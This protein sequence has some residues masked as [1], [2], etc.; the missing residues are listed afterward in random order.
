M[1]YHAEAS[2]SASGQEPSPS[3]TSN[4]DRPVE[5]TVPVYKLGGGDRSY[6]TQIIKTGSR[7][8]SREAVSIYESYYQLQRSG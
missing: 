5:F 6:T 4:A 8:S 2:L 7:D 3:R 1:S